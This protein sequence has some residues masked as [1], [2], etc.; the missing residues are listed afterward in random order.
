MACKCLLGAGLNHLKSHE[1]GKAVR[2]AREAT[3]LSQAAGTAAVA[4]D[5]AAPASAPA[6]HLHFDTAFGDS[7]ASVYQKVRKHNRASKEYRQFEH[8]SKHFQESV[9][10]PYLL[11]PSLHVACTL[12]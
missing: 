1:G 7:S 9:N 4:F 2:C 6:D 12:S 5:K 11:Q 10:S 8:A 3:S